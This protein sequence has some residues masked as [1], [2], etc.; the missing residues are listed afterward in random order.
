MKE[1][2]LGFRFTFRSLLLPSKFTQRFL[3]A[4]LNVFL[5]HIFSRIDI[6]IDDGLDHGSVRVAGLDGWIETESAGGR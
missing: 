3:H 4:V 5:H 1:I 6:V 2:M